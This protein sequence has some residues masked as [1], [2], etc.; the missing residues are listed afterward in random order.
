[1][2]F[3]IPFL[4]VLPSFDTVHFECSKAWVPL[5]PI[6]GLKKFRECALS[7]D[8]GRYVKL[9][10]AQIWEETEDTSLYGLLQDEKRGFKIH[11][12]D[13]ASMVN[14]NKGCNV[15]VSIPSLISYSNKADGI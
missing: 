14:A 15:F 4:D 11:W 10:K 6:Q 9:V 8:I 5:D 1:M 12:R 3:E 13:Q 2:R 7:G